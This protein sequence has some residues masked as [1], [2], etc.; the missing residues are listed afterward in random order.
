MQYYRI[1]WANLICY[2]LK[3]KY[4]IQ[5]FQNTLKMTFYK[6]NNTKFSSGVIDTNSNI[7]KYTQRPPNTGIFKVFRLFVKPNL[8]AWTYPVT[9]LSVMRQARSEVRAEFPFIFPRDVS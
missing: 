4:Q 7:T 8:G 1:H 3:E 9:V 5:I 6:S 2:F